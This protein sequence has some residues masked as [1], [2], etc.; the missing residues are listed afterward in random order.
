[1]VAFLTISKTE[2]VSTVEILHL[3]RQ[4]TVSPAWSISLLQMAWRGKAQG[5]S[6]SMV[7][8]HWGPVTHVCANKLT[9]IGSDIIW[10]NA[11][12]LIY[13][14]TVTNFSEIWIEIHTFKN[15]HLKMSSG[16]WRP[17]CLGL[18]VFWPSYPTTSLFQHQKGLWIMSDDPFTRQWVI[19]S[20][21][22]VK[23]CALFQY[24]FF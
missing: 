12:I 24:E 3:G 6:A 17:F 15:M 11:G 23:A 5:V 19:V 7:L 20:P 14:P 10:T 13:G 2:I 9:S 16:K 8:T 1:M 4:G 22:P 18:N 21:F